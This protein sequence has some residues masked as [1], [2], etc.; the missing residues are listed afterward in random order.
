[1]KTKEELKQITKRITG[2]ECTIDNYSNQSAEIW[3]KMW[4]LPF[5]MLKDLE[6]E[7]EILDIWIDGNYLALHVKP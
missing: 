7:L 1:M 2:I 4:L 5:S 6:K 3:L